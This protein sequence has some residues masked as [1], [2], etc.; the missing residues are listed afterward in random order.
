LRHLLAD[1]PGL[2]EVT[3]LKREPREFSVG[4]I[5]REIRRGEQIQSLYRLTQRLLPGLQISGAVLLSR[6]T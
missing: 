1:S 6:E 3:Q 2:Y 5:K 4:E